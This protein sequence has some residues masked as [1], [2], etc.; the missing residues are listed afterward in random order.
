MANLGVVYYNRASKMLCR[1]AVSAHT[2]RKHYAGPVTLLSQGDPS[3]GPCRQIADRFGLDFK[4]V[5]YAETP[6]RKGATYINATLCYKHV[7]YDATIWMDSD[8]IVCGDITPLHALALKHDFVATQI[9]EWNSKKGS[10]IGKRIEHWRGLLPDEWLEASYAMNWGV[11]CGVFAFKRGSVFMRDWWAFAVKGL[12]TR[13]PDEVCC[14]IMLPVYPHAKA[15]NIFNV[16]CKYGMA[17]H[18][19]DARIVHFHGNKHCRFRRDRKTKAI[20]REHSNRSALW[21]PQFEEIREW[22]LVQKYIRSDRMLRKYLPIW[23][24]VKNGNV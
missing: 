4:K 21:Y 3:H 11:N 20:T 16:S 6:D 22:P 19:A 1:L 13:I 15:P 2:L 7:G 8:T 23:D 24:E 5:E 18:Y 9:A 17:A 10:R 12:H 14:Q